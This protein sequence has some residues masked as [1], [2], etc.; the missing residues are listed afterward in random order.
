ML[1]TLDSLMPETAKLIAPGLD[2]DLVLNNINKL[3]DFCKH[4]GLHTIFST[5]VCELNVAELKEIEQY[6]AKLFKP[7]RYGNKA[8][9]IAFG[10]ETDDEIAAAIKSA[11]PLWTDKFREC[12]FNLV[13]GK[14]V[15]LYDKRC[16][17]TGRKCQNVP[18]I[19]Y[20]GALGPCCHDQYYHSIIGNVLEAGSVDKLL[21]SPK[22]LE[23][24]RKAR[25][26]ELPICR[27]CN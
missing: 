19:R 9:G 27:V 11:G 12:R 6:L 1:I 16:W 18:I 21:Q 3:S 10:C 14:V 8:F 23:I 26:L 22:G 2:L 15:P 7:L 5:N 4:S 20:D 24:M 17:P 13:D 25:N